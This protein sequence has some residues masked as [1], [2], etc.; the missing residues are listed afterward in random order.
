MLSKSIKYMQLAAAYVRLN[1]LAQLEYRGAFISQVV[2]MILNDVIWVIFWCL[3]FNRFPVLRGWTMSDF[4]TLW[5]LSASGFGLSAAVF[6][7]SLQLPVLIAR[8]QLD[9]W[10]L[11]P[12]A[13][14]PHLLLG[15]MS[16]TAIGDI[17]FGYVV[18]IAVVHPDLPHF[19]L[20]AALSLCVAMVFVGFNIATGSLSFY[21][22]NAEGLAEQLRFA[23]IT[24]STYPS[25]LFEGAIKVVLYTLIPAG[26]IS[27][28]PVESLRSLSWQ[29]AA[30]SLAG[31][32][33]VLAVGVAMFYHG[34]S[35]YESGNLVEMRG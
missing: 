16:A 31:A 30:L 17:L 28:L 27:Y 19:L 8:G 12:R 3:F 25:T 4:L 9:V 35:R 6:G 5:C 33:A 23:L 15:R 1:L 10:M 13:L 22:G 21:L 26:F 24:F 14:L 11:Y 18:Y 20:F 29:D 32:L 34:M 2:S 7:N